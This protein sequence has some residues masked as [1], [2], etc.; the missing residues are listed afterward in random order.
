MQ[1]IK[2][3]E[4]ARL[5]GFPI[6]TIQYYERRGLLQPASRMEN[7]YRLYGEEEVARLG[8]IKQAKLLGLT[9]EEI[10]ELVDA[11]SECHRGEIMPRLEELLDEKLRET[12]ARIR[13]LE[14]F[15]QSLLYY[16]RQVSGA[17]PEQSCGEKA[18]FCGCLETVTAETRTSDAEGLDSFLDRSES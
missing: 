6:R 18:S 3:G 11:A 10:R 13:E 17:D 14:A 7:G 12:E 8:F 2:I 15:Q 4:C 9:L 1:L 5:S 16:R